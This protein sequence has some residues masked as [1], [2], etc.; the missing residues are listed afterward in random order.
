MLTLTDNACT[1]VHDLTERAGLAD[2]GGLRITEAPD[3][4]SFELALVPRPAEGDE[5]LEQSGARV[6]LAPEAST[7]LAELELDATVS[8]E[9]PGFALLQRP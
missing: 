3:R 8:D 1:V 4:T 5:L 6:F 9:G 2:D 7:A